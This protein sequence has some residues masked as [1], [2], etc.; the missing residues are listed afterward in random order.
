[1]LRIV[2]ALILFVGIVSDARMITPDALPKRYVLIQTGAFKKE[3]SVREN[4]EKLSAFTLLR[5]DENGLTRIFVV[6]TPGHRR[7]ILKRVRKII[8]DAFVRSR[9]IA[10]T[11]PHETM[12]K[13]SVDGAK[14]T[15]KE[16][17][18]K[19]LPL[20]SKA[21]LQTRKKFF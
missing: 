11:K 12:Q 21:I 20:D 6:T 10:R 7:A 8:P 14:P 16:D 5:I 19:E 15:F 17:I 3:Q 2:L 9:F 4:I 18:S 1:M 13:P